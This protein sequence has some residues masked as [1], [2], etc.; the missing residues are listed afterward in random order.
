MTLASGSRLGPYEVLALIGAGGM[1]EVYRARD[2]RLG[3]DVAIKVLP[4]SL[5]ADPE[6]LQR[7]EQ[8]ARSA[9][10]LNH[11]NIVTIHDVGQ[12]GGVSWIAMELV[13]GQSLRQLLAAGALPLPRAL[14]IGA[15]V[16]EGLGRAHAARIVHR[17]LK[18]EN[19]MVTA[20]GLVKILDF[21]L[22]KPVPGAADSQSQAPTAAH[23]TEAGIVLGTIGYMSPEQATGRPVDYR[24]DQFAL[25]AML[26]EMA[27]GRR[28]FARPTAVETLSAI[29]KDEPPPLAAVNPGAPEP[30][31]WIVRRCLAKEPEDRYHSTRDLAR[32]LAGLRDR[33]SGPVA[34]APEPPARKVKNGRYLAVGLVLAGL[35]AVG[36][37]AV[38]GRWNAPGGVHTLAVLPLQAISGSAEDAALGLGIADTIIRGFSRTR[39]LTVRPLSA[40]QKYAKSN[41]DALAAA[42][43]LRADAVLEGSLQ[44]SGEKL[45]VSVNLLRAGDGRSMWTESFDVPASEVFAVEDAVSD[46]VVARLRL[47]LDPSQR[48]RLKKR[49]TE[50]AEAYDAFARGLAEGDQSGPGTGGEHNV[51]AI[52]AF[53]RA[54]ALDPGYA[55]A[56]ARLAES[57]LWRDFF[58]EPGA[59]YLEKAKRAMAEAERLDPQLADAHVARYQL[60]WSHYQ[61]FDLETAMRELRTARRLDP[62]VSRG[63]LP[64]LYAHMGLADAFRREMA[65]DLEQ[66]PSSDL[67]RAFD[68]EGLVLLGEAEEAL[69]LAKRHGKPNSA[70]RLTM[71]LLSLGRF[72][73]ARAAADAVL[74]QSPGHHNAVAVRELVAAASGERA[75]DETALARALEAGKLLRDHH[76]TLYAVAC[77]R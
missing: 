66:D 70:A 74:A 37:F 49:F 17:D 54:V 2:G 19:V 33:R 30:L 50:N 27:S 76:H 57:Y 18:P 42:R 61:G 51:R 43:E 77:I 38:L 68:V 45:R 13:E 6:R 23:Q 1:G 4:E 65:R 59:G 40:V 28:A 67:A 41:V 63:D 26:Y 15:Q 53:E 71:S 35:V 56:H 21:G 24:S 36:A 5:A 44:R 20:D 31:E 11:P 34:A 62:S 14:A 3:R 52:A 48:D 22:A 64:I 32:D 25:G 69:A 16:A 9:S 46:A 8:E 55:L 12:T 58:F 10:A 47:H 72:D 7:F 29:L 75:P 39:A 73:E 60:A